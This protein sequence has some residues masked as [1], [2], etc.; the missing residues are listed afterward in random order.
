MAKISVSFGVTIENET[1]DPH[2]EQVI[3]F[4]KSDVR[5]DDIDLEGD[6]DAQL[7]DITNGYDKVFKAIAPK[8]LK[9]LKVKSE[10]S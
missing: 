10:K 8:L 6:I 9:K 5:I 3:R 1:K 7:E 2:R 4:T